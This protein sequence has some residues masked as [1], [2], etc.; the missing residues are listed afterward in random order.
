MTLLAPRLMTKAEAAAYCCL[1]T[2]RFGQWVREGKVSPAI[3]D[4]HRWDRR[5]LDRDLDR[6]SGIDTSRPSPL[7]DW[8][9]RR[10]ARHA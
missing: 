4:T 9:A 6:L 5:A 2:E 7:A 3:P 1:S 10:D 8:K